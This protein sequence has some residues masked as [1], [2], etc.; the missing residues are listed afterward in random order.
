MAA[1]SSTHPL[2][3]VE[4]WS[5]SESKHGESKLPL[6]IPYDRKEIQYAIHEYI[7][8]NYPITNLDQIY[9]AALDNMDIKE[10]DIDPVIKLQ[11]YELITGELER[12]ERELER[13]GEYIASHP[14]TISTYLHPYFAKEGKV[15]EEKYSLFR[16]KSE[17]EILFLIYLTTKHGDICTFIP[18]KIEAKIN[19]LGEI[20]G[21]SE[22]GITWH[23]VKEEKEE[24]EKKKVIKERKCI[25]EL[26]IPPEVAE[27]LKTCEKRFVAIPLG[28]SYGAST[29]HANIIIY[30]RLNN[31]V[32]RFEPHGG[33]SELYGLE[34]EYEKDK[35]D[36]ELKTAFSLILGHDINYLSA[37]DIVH[38]SLFRIWR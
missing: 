6:S 21:L 20:S 7:L 34:K 18:N 2:N 3:L 13:A 28:L 29:G 15:K 30:D 14:Y 32:E 25:H 33:G 27:N 8:K 5:A 31:T 23:C 4:L 17:Y 38:P 11:I 1:T 37:S 10:S 35:L 24:K 36:L 22:S 16:G 26:K 12:Y 19:I 9:V